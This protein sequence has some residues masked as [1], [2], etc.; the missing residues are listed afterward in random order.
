MTAVM[1]I[2][3]V[4]LAMVGHFDDK[5]L[6]VAVVAAERVVAQCGRCAQTC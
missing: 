3:V 4:M 5:S 1:P 6:V 2:V